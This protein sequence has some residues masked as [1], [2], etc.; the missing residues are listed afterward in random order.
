MSNSE[1]YN[2]GNLNIC[3]GNIYKT[4]FEL[5]VHNTNDGDLEPGVLWIA[6]GKM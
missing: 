2:Y 4:G 6:V 1:D 5:H 3:I